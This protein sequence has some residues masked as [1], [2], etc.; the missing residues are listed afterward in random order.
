MSQG[1]DITSVPGYPLRIHTTTT[2]HVYGSTTDLSNPYT[3]I[4]VP[5][6][7]D[8]LDLDLGQTTRDVLFTSF[9][10]FVLVLALGRLV[11]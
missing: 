4:H 1:E 9:C 5:C 2:T 11:D 6:V 7:I 10:L 3:L 8:N